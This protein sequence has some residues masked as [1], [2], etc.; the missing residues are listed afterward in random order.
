MMLCTIISPVLSTARAEDLD[1]AVKALGTP[2]GIACVPDCGDADAALKL[3]RETEMLVLALDADMAAVVGARQRAADAGLLGRRL[4]VEQGTVEAIPF[5]DNYVDLIVLTGMSEKDLS[6]KARAE[7]LRVLAPIR[8]RAVLAD[9]AI[10]KPELPGSD[11][12]THRLHGP[13]NNPVSQDTVFQFP[14]ILQYREMPAFSSYVGAALT[15]RGV[16]VELNDWVYHDVQRVGLCGRIFARS[17]YNGRILWDAVLPEGIE[18][19]MPVFAIAGSDLLMPA[20]GRASVLRRDLMTGAEKR[21]IELGGGDRR[22]RWLAAEDGLL[23]ALLGGPSIVRS[24]FGWSIQ[25]DVFQEQEEARS[26]FGSTIVAWDLERGER[27]WTHTEPSPIDFRTVAVHDGRLYFYS[28]QPRLACLDVSDGNLIW[29]NTDE[30]CSADLRRPPAIR[31]GNIRGM[32]TLKVGDGLVHLALMEANKGLLFREDDGAAICTIK[33]PRGGSYA[34]QKTFILDGECYLN[35]SAID[36]ES[37]WRGTAKAVPSP[38]GLA[39]CG[40]VTYS[41]GTGAVGHATLGYK[42]PCGVGAWVAGGTLIYGPSICTCDN[43]SLGAGGYVSGGTV[44]KHVTTSPEHPL[45]QGA[46]FGRKPAARA[47]ADSADWS[48]YQGGTA[49]R[50]S[51]SVAVGRAPSLRWRHEP[52][53]PFTVT[54]LYNQ[55]VDHFDERPAPVTCAGGLVYAAASDGI[56]RAHRISDGVPVWSMF[57]NGPVLTSPAYA[58]GRLFVPCADGWVY[59]LEAATGELIWKRRVAPMERRIAVFGQ[60]MSTWPVFSLAVADGT[61]YASAGM[62]ILCGSATMALKADTGEIVWRRWLEPEI[63]G[64]QQAPEGDGV[65]FGGTT[66]ITGDCVWVAAYGTQPLCLDRHDGSVVP[67]PDDVKNFRKGFFNFRGCYTMQGQNLI[68]L[69]DRCVLGGGGALLE[70]QHVREGKWKRMEYKLYFADD[71]GRF[72]YGKVPRRVLNVARIAPVCDEELIAFAAPPPEDERGRPNRG[73]LFATR[74][75]N[76]WRT[77]DFTDEAVK[78]LASNPL[79]DKVAWRDVTRPMDMGR[80]L[81]RKPE[82][83]VSAMAFAAD[84]LLVAHGTG[85]VDLSDGRSGYDLSERS[86]LAT[87]EAWVLSAYARGSGEEIWRTE[88]PDEP[89]PNGIAIAADGSVLVMLRDGGLVCIRG[90]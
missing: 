84:A 68:A 20:G 16:Q 71:R 13:D 7:I 58:G 47:G 62:S 70:N 61:V 5:A 88:L 56:V 67:M 38:G 57:V 42:A 21:P 18:A 87:Y 19:N 11:W 9:V 59:A 1:D 39:W 14:P 72:D 35:D 27:L 82:L 79:D 69:G 2:R 48:A 90:R 89:I 26:L 3:A 80:A 23:L 36:R 54:K 73:S 28:E 40:I 45:V 60:V 50:G 29:E 41:R 66:T 77:S 49:H 65:G 74:G 32:S 44:Y 12:W 24:P 43:H 31:N 17:I 4:Y 76:V 51:T 83:D 46:A 53:K 6:V 22:V 75:L 55:R 63:A 37:G 78:M 81:W 33:H 15:A 52:Q 10:T 8:G 64:S 30:G 25:K 85:G 34:G 86:A